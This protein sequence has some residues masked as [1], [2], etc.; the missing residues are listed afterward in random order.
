MKPSTALD[1]ATRKTSRWF[2]AGSHRGEIDQILDLYWGGPE[3]RITGLTVRII[4]LNLLALIGLLFG[5][6]S[7]G[8]YQTIVIN[9]KIKV[10]ETEIFLVAAALSQSPLRELGPNSHSQGTDE[11][12]RMTSMLSETLDKRIIVFDQA[13]H[14][15]ADSQKIKTATSPVFTLAPEPQEDRSLGIITLKDV[16]AFFV[17]LIP[18]VTELQP[19]IEIDAQNASAFPDAA[20]AMRGEISLSAWSAPR[21]KTVITAAM[22]IVND[23]RSLGVVMLYSDG[24]DIEAAVVDA[25]YDL[26]RIFFITLV[27]TVLLSVY[28]SGVIA[29]PLR[30]L[31]K[32][33]E[34]V[35]KGKAD[36]TEIPDMSHRKDEIGEL[37]LVL[38]D[39]THA[40]WERMDSIEAFAADVAHEIKNPLSSLKSAVETAHIVKKKEDLH[41][42][43]GIIQHDVERLDRLITDISHASRLDAEL[44][45]EN[46]VRVDLKK[47]LRNLI[48]VYKEPLERDYNS[49]ENIQQATKDGIKIK[50]F[51]PDGEDVFVSGSETRLIQVFQ[52]IIANALSFSPHGSTILI[53]LERAPNRISLFFEDEGPGIPE[54]KLKS[55]FE[56]F[57]SERPRHEDFGHHSGLGLSICRQI[58]AAHNGIVFAE[59]RVN[60][61]GKIKGARFVVILNTVS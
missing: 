58:I 7:I 19:Y 23:L 9:S 16:T 61:E 35:R 45:R 28:L 3:R 56:R 17:S 26:L 15:I 25:W 11:I 48:N 52:N 21:G 33:A 10:L 50:L 32:A 14:K 36:F 59:N 29:R 30:K 47:L 51:M 43:L 6:F 60:A 20:K 53:S 44:S 27:V 41:K 49:T 24:R 55:V 5:V 37:S 39:M 13:G 2:R 12:D 46:F 40:L 57:Y 31:A 54:N 22:P 38:R 4:G 1:T 42:L 18:K 8:Q 34:N